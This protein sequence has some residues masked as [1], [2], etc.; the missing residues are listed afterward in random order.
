MYA[1]FSIHVVLLQIPWLWSRILEH[2]AY[3]TATWLET[4][5]LS[6]EWRWKL[7]FDDTKIHG[8]SRI[9]RMVI[10]S[11]AD[12]TSRR[13]IRFLHSIDVWYIAF[14][15]I[16]VK[17]LLI[18]II[19]LRRRSSDDVHSSRGHRNGSRPI[20]IP[21]KTTPLLATFKH[22]NVLI[23]YINNWNAE[24]EIAKFI[25]RCYTT[26]KLFKEKS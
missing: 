13:F 19:S 17:P 18:W 26:Y 16:D 10:L 9:S 14:S 2:L 4:F 1:V 15:C 25:S 11:R 21:Y 3:I 22:L 7:F 23:C 20:V 24:R 6:S 5:K 12:G 8:W